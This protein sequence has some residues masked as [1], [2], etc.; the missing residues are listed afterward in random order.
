MSVGKAAIMN[1]S[2]L[3]KKAMWSETGTSSDN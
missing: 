1:N 3:E 2:F